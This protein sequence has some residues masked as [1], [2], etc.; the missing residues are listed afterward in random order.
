[1]PGLTMAS[2]PVRRR[3]ARFTLAV[4]LVPTAGCGDA[5]APAPTTRPPDP[6]PQPT[7][8]DGIFVAG[9]DGSAPVAVVSGATSIVSAR[10]RCGCS[11]PSWT[12][13]SARIIFV[14]AGNA[15]DPDYARELESSARTVCL[16][17]VRSDAL[18]SMIRAADLVVMPNIA[19]PDAI[20]VEGF[21][22]AAVEATALGGR[23]LASA[24]DGIT[25]AVV[26]G[27]TGRLVPPGDVAAWVE[28]TI[29]ALDA[30]PAGTTPSRMHVAEAT[31]RLFSRQRQIDAFLPLLSNA[32]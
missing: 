11:S 30:E 18:A 32:Q 6:P 22:L 5:V 26:D 2:W 13:D 15:P 31:R 3:L 4:L 12:C 10:P 17:R 8:T 19:T 29:Q 28:A 27:V 14:V 25:D 1:M 9:A 7:T 21:G 20:D 16:G 24:I 23:L